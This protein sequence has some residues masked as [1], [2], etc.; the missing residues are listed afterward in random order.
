MI[1]FRATLGSTTADVHLCTRAA[2]DSYGHP[3]SNARGAK[4]VSPRLTHGPPKPELGS[5]GVE[6]RRCP[7]VLLRLRRIVHRRHRTSR[8]CQSRSGNNS[9]PVIG[10]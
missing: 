7:A 8:L 10:G 9:P 1:A 2:A 4:A 5:S 3:F 6:L